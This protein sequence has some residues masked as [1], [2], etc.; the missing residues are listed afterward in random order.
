MLFRSMV[1][2]SRLVKYGEVGLIR[3]GLVLILGLVIGSVCV[4]WNEMKRDL[5][6]VV[7]LD[8]ERLTVHC[9]IGEPTPCWRDSSVIFGHDYETAGCSDRDSIHTWRAMDVLKRAD[10][11]A[12]HGALSDRRAASR[13]TGYER[14]I[15]A[16]FLND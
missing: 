2:K 9:F 10:F 13:L 11:R 16:R 5:S 6:V 1:L 12:G 4:N 15:R 14:H 3:R 7:G 8:L